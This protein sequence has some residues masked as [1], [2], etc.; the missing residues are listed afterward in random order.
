[1][2]KTAF[3][4]NMY[5][6]LQ[7][8]ENSNLQTVFD[9]IKYIIFLICFILASSVMMLIPV[10]LFYSV[11]GDFIKKTSYSNKI[12]EEMGR[13]ENNSKYLQF[14]CDK[15]IKISSNLFKNFIALATWNIFS[16]FYIIFWFENFSDGLKE[17]FYFPFA[18]LQSLSKN[19]I[20]DSIYKFQSNWLFMSAIIVLTF[21]FSFLGKYIG[22]DIA[23]SW[24]KKLN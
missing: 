24:V 20:F 17:Y 4:F 16:L 8:S 9:S 18:I 15:Y 10:V 5:S 6:F 12:K 19:E 21:S 13:K 7:V 2:K 14:I 11:I 1:M 3:V 22:R 23:E